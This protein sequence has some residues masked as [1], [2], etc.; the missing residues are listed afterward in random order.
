M[1]RVRKL[2]RRRGDDSP[3]GFGGDFL[4]IR[5]NFNFRLR[6]GGILVSPTLD[7]AT[8]FE[9]WFDVPPLVA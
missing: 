9:K 1:T 8:D 6:H 4:W 7:K 2:R 5:E 3:S